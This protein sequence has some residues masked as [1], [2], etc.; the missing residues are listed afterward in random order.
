MFKAKMNSGSRAVFRAAPRI[1]VTIPIR[2]K[3]WALMKGFMPRLTSTGMVPA[4]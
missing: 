1:T 3:P 4:T 2:G